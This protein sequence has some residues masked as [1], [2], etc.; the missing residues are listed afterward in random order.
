MCSLQHRHAVTGKFDS[1]NLPHQ[2]SKGL[3]ESADVRCSIDRFCMTRFA[4]AELKEGL[5][6]GQAEGSFACN[7]CQ[8][9]LLH[10]AH[11]FAILLQEC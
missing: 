5:F 11:K 7:H 6:W 2:L 9:P 10:V 8:E 4:P 3:G 1:A